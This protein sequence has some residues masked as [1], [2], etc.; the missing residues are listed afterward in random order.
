MSS[1]TWGVFPVPPTV[2]FPT[3]IKGDGISLLLEYALVEEK[4]AQAY[5][6]TIESRRADRGADYYFFFIT[7][8]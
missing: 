7:P 5:P 6:Q 4:V 8:R 1:S 3:Q 2:I